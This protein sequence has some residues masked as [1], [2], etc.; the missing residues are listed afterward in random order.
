V[1][2][3]LRKIKPTAG[4]FAIAFS[5]CFPSSRGTP[6]IHTA[7]KID[8]KPRQ[9]LPIIIETTSKTAGLCRRACCSRAAKR[10]I[11]AV[12]TKSLMSELSEGVV[13]SPR[14]RGK[15]LFRDVIPPLDSKNLNV[16]FPECNLRFSTA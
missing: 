8:G 7:I 3:G 15:R 4:S 12:G 14:A 1:D 5:A 9:Y 16:C 13:P 6:T 2:V 10:S 11:R